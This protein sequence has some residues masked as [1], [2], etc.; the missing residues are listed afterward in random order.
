MTG[1]MIAAQRHPK[2]AR[3]HCGTENLHREAHK[4]PRQKSLF[5][6][7][8]SLSSSQFPVNSTR[9]SVTSRIASNS[10]F[11]CYLIFSSRHLNAT[12]VKRNF[13]EKFNTRLRFF[14]ASRTLH[15]I[16]QLD[17][18]DRSSVECGA[19]SRRAKGSSSLTAI[20]RTSRHFLKQSETTLAARC[21]VA[22]PTSSVAIIS[23]AGVSGTFLHSHRGART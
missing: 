10:R 8:T 2:L 16:S 17:F 5:L 21:T 18:C 22:P 19:S 1:P 20:C 12:P 23:V 9:H 15:N 14:A 13:V 4:S 6:L 3:L 11:I 7:D